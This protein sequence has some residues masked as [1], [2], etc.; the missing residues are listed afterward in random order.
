[1][2]APFRPPTRAQRV[3]AAG[4]LDG[5]SPR[6]RRAFEPDDAFEPLPPPGPADWLANH[7][8]RGQ[9]FEQFQASRPNRPGARRNVLYLQQL[10]EFGDHAPSPDLLRR[11]AAAFFGLE[12]RLLDPASTS[13]I[14]SRPN[15]W[16]GQTQLL[17]SDLL[18][19][20]KRRLPSD[21][22]ALVGITMTDLYPEASWNFVFGQASLRD[23]V[24]VYSFARYTAA[25]S[26]L[27]LRRSVKVL[28]HE[29][30]HMFGIE[31]C[32]WY[33][34]LMNG[35]NHLAEADARPLHLCPADLRK[36][37]WSTGS[38]VVVRYR[39]LRDFYRAVG[40]DDEVRWLERRIGWI[41]MDRG[42]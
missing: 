3:A 21:A 7:P 8:E 4:P 34:C 17:A 35:S 30:G 11:F 12:V 14:T 2:A 40:F 13:G 16:T 26:R 9:T 5:L 42:S 10:G 24:G 20:L 15:P 27:V 22:F 19:F 39:K 36:L 28:A 33:H 6:E 1:M 25:D 31:H 41:E 23:R 29:T 32:V 38:D 18:V 37:T